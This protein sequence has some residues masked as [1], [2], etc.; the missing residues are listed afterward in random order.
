M[1]VA[2]GSLVVPAFAQDPGV[3]AAA[4]GGQG[5]LPAGALVYP[6]AGATG[7][8]LNPGLILRLEQ[9]ISSPSIDPRFFS[10]DDQALGDGL[11]LRDDSG[12][13]LAGG[14]MVTVETAR[15][16]GAPQALPSAHVEISAGPFALSP[17]SHYEVLS[18]LAI[19]PAD[20]GVHVVCLQDEFVEIGDF[21]TGAEFD[22]Q[23]PI[24]ASVAE[25]E[26]PGQCLTSLSVVA[27]DDHAPASALRFGIDTVAY[28]GPN[29]A[30]PTP[31]VPIDEPRTTVLVV[32]I[33]PSNNRGQAFE[34]EV[35]SCY[36]PVT[37]ILQ[38]APA[39]PAP[40]SREAASPG[41][42][43]VLRPTPAPSA[44]SAISMFVLLTVLPIARRRVRRK[45]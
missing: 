29:V 32:P 20:G 28:L 22:R 8:V 36:V 11:L 38:P 21:T 4:P 43:C 26:S 15:P 37:D 7:V 6:P 31:S 42:G 5:P 33:D 14:R 19:C 16:F 27:S 10:P 9:T 30:L 39:P 17:Q 2:G 1:G 44:I 40:A 41:S 35:E 13:L 12:R 34:L 25:G 3:D 24:I 23:G 45:G 18:R